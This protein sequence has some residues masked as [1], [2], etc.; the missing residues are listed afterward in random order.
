MSVIQG[1][2]VITGATQRDIV[3]A[4]VPTDGTS[5]DGA[6]HS[7]IGDK[8]RDQTNGDVYINAGTKASP[9]WKLVTRAA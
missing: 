4:G 5:G 6:G 8:Y 2:V 1:G 7:E 3:G 9:T